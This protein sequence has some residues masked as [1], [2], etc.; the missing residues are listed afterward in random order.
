MLIVNSNKFQNRL[1][2]QSVC[3]GLGQKQRGL[4]LGPQCLKDHG[5][6][7][8]LSSPGR[9][10]FDAGNLAPQVQESVDTWNLI[11][12]LR[13][14]SFQYLQKDSSLLTLGGD[15]SIAIGTVQASLMKNPQTRVLWVDAHGDI[16]TPETSLSGNLHGMPLAALLGLF[17]TPI[18]GPCLLPEN[19]LL[20][21]VRDL[22]PG[23]KVF[24]QQLQV[25][26]ITAEATHLN[27]QSAHQ[28]ILSWIKKSPS[29]PLHVSFDIDSLD[30]SIAPATGLRVSGGLTG[31][32]ALK[33]LSQVANFG[34]L[35]SMDFV[36]LNPLMANSAAEL[37]KTLALSEA[38]LK[39]AFPWTSAG[40]CFLDPVV[41]RS[42]ETVS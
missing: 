15:H 22:D 38:L 36:E 1:T 18:G 30:P 26:V 39:E 4:E 20:I 37:A 34:N 2:V 8:S 9:R 5:L 33:L 14:K 28:Q 24:L 35:L 40:E 21:G 19:I 10:I 16:N 31:P 12:R 27:P 29:S 11:Q 3:S 7:K 25:K 23:E 41:N 17:A 13:E 42:L 6:L 32:F